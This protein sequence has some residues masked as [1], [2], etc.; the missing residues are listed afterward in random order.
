[1]VNHVGARNRKIRIALGPVI[2]AIPI[3]DTKTSREIAET[4]NKSNSRWSIAPGTMS[5]LLKERDDL[6]YDKKTEKWV[7]V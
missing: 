4:L 6:Q 1:M 7:R 2:N 5:N 3:G